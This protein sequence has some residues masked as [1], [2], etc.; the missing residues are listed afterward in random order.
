MARCTLCHGMKMLPNFMDAPNGPRCAC[1]RPSAHQSGWCGVEHPHV[2]CPRCCQDADLLRA[3][4]HSTT[5]DERDALLDEA[6]D[7]LGD[8]LD[9][10][11]LNLVNHGLTKPRAE[12]LYEKLSR[13]P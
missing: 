12:E 2:P 10:D 4:Q 6:C 1:G 13:L 3:W 8:I 7:V 11:V 5:N 9:L